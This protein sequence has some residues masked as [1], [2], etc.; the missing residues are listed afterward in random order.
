MTGEDKGC[1]ILLFEHNGFEVFWDGGASIRVRD[2]EFTVAVDPGPDSPIF[3]AGIVLITGEYPHY[4]YEALKKVVGRGTCVVVPESLNDKEI[5][6][7]DVEYVDRGEALDIFGV[8]IET[9]GEPEGGLSYRFD[10]QGTSFYASGNSGYREEVIQLEN[11]IDIAFLQASSKVTEEDVIRT[12]VRIKP[13]VVVPYLYGS[14]FGQGLNQD[15]L[16]ADLE[17]RNI[18]CQLL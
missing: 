8:E 12:A 5:P 15:N 18:H 10:M 16:K 4:N 7:H 17:D 9:L 3:E 1:C 13:E 6:C 11:M 2:R 14:N